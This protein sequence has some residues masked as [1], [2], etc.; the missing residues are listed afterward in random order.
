MD[1]HLDP[2]PVA[3]ILTTL[4]PDANA[5]AIARTL[6]SERLAACVNV[7]PVMTSVFRWQGN[8]EQDR[9]QQLVIKTAAGSIHAIE[10]RLR[11]LHPYDLPEFL[12]IPAGG[13]T[14]YLDWVR[15]SVDG[16]KR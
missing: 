5:T 6:V 1:Q 13:S 15:G 10:A 11:E 8:I 7:L 3:I 2:H 4:G 14:A 12:V 9:E 16:P